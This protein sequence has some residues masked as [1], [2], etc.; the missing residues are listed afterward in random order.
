MRRI[1]LP[2]L[3]VV[4]AVSAVFVLGQDNA[5]T[6]EVQ[7]I[8]QITVANATCG[9]EVNGTIS[10]TPEVTSEASS[11]AAS[12]GA[13]LKSPPY[14]LLTLGADCADVIENLHVPN[15]GT[16]WIKFSVAENEAPWQ[17]FAAVPGDAHPPKFD[18]R[19]RFVGCEIPDEGE[20]TCRALWAFEGTTY[21]L[22]IPLVVRTAYIAPVVAAPAV[23]TAAP[24]PV[25]T[26]NSG[27]WGSCGSCTTCGG[28]VEHCVLAPDNTCVWD[29]ERCE[30]R[31]PGD[32]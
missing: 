26:P 27:V 29:A 15:N 17:E 22:Q 6:P 16:I 8:L 9:M 25:S 1:L 10:V 28:P 13:T 11:A 21:L 18:K 32:N 20:Q 14:P 5:S 12:I 3:V 4:L 7:S 24:V 30:H 19:G 2:L 31:K 23:S